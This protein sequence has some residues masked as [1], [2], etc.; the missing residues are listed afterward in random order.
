MNL[1]SLEVMVV[2]QQKIKRETSM[3]INT[4]LDTKKIIY[5]M[6]ARGCNSL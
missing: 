1:V 2:S 3:I 4:N 5:L 6:L